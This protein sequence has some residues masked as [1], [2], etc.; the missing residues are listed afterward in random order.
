MS[1]FLMPLIAP[2]I[3]KVVTLVVL[4]AL[5]LHFRLLAKTFLLAVNRLFFIGLVC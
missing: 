4:A 2:F 5:H 3:S 1:Q